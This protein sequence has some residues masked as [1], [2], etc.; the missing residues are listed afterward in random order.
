MKEIIDEIGFP[1]IP[2]V[3]KEGSHNAWLLIQHADRDIEFQEK[4]LELMESANPD[5]VIQKDIA[6][7]EDR[8]RVNGKRPQLY[9]TQFTQSNGEHILQPIENIEE[10]DERRAKMGMDTL[11]DQIRLMY[12]KHP[13]NSK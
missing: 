8:I 3:G 11:E 6:Y 9:G 13:L 10:V 4:C 12:K 2:L 5:V 7:L 1:T